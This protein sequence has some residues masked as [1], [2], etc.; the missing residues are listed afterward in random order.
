M[1]D[2]KLFVFDFDGTALGGHVPYDQFPR[3]FARF[4]DGLPDLGIR[5]A[6]NTTWSLEAQLTLI[7]R[8]RVKSEPAF[9]TGQTG[10][11]L[12][13]VEGGRLVPDLEYEKSTL[14][15]ERRFKKKVWP[16][17]RETFLK[18]LDERLVDRIS[19]GFYD[20]NMITFTC[21]KGRAARAWEVLDPLLSSGL[22]YSWAGTVGGNTATLLPK[23][24]H[25]GNI[26]KTMQKRLGVGPE[27]TIVAGDG[28][29][30]LHMFERRCARWMV[31]PAN[32]DP[33][34]KQKVESLGGVVATKEFSW[35]VVSGL[36]KVLAQLGYPGA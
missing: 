28:T 3:P 29:N 15:R 9:L 35:G 32:A 1:N 12:A 20:Q 31:C 22:Y 11:L 21:E 23:Y 34:V 17:V 6:T 26:I 2:L 24:F 14:R 30:D 19:F 25:K 8:S 33:L 4:L 13:T 36:Q 10:R 5:W 27:Q 7:K 16:Q 18:L